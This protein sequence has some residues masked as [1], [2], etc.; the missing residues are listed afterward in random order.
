MGTSGSRIVILKN[1]VAA[2]VGDWY[3]L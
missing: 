3:T 1:G 2:Y